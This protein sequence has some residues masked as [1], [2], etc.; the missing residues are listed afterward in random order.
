MDKNNINTINNWGKY[1]I[2]RLNNFINKK[3]YKDYK[4]LNE[5]NKHRPFGPQNLFCLAPFNSMFFDQKGRVRP[6]WDLITDYEYFPNKSLKEIWKGDIFKKLR[7]NF[8]ANDLS[9]MCG[10]CRK[11]LSDKSFYNVK[12]TKFDNYPINKSEFPSYMEF[13]CENTCNLECIM[14]SGEL[15]SSIRNKSEHISAIKSPYGNDFVKQLEEFI[16]HLKVANF[17]GGEPFLIK[18]YYDIWHLMNKI[19]PNISIYISTNATVLNERIKNILNNGKFS[20]NVSIDSLKKEVFEKIRKNGSF[21]TVMKNIIELN[22]YTKL[23]KTYFNIN[24]CIIRENWEEIPEI[25]N[26][27]NK[28]DSTIFFCEVIQP[29]NQAIW[30]L[31]STEIEKIQ[32]YLSGFSFPLKTKNQKYNNVQ[33]ISYI[34]KLEY[35][36]NKAEQLEKDINKEIRVVN[37]E[38]IIELIINHYSKHNNSIEFINKI[39]E[40][41]NGLNNNM[42]TSD[43][44]DKLFNLPDDF[45][46]SIFLNESKETIINQL[47]VLKYY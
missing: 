22:K 2:F 43:L 13:V 34:K 12:S 25:I 38:Q 6:C 18:I 30:T 8:S 4:L 36:K 14:C 31:H 37:K 16:P 24:T 21:E 17:I 7:D 41:V 28:L 42:L 1:S 44:T 11:S 3:N 9:L 27:C 10:I 19:N 45:V 32:Q 39:E 20:F 29:E 47:L 46:L 15:S 5:F 23:K 33:Y 35:W 26:F 40:I